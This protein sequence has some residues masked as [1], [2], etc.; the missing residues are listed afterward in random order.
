MRENQNRDFSQ[1]PTAGVFTADHYYQAIENMQEH[2]CFNV[3]WNKLFRRSVIVENSLKMDTSIS[4]GEDLLFV[5]SY[6]QHIR[7]QICLVEKPLYCYFISTNGLQSNFAN[8]QLRLGQLQCIRLLYDKFKYPLAGFYMEAM[9]T[10]YIVLLEN[11]ESSKN[12]HD[13][14]RQPI[15]VEI[16][17]SHFHCGKKYEILRTLLK[18]QN[19]SLILVAVKIFRLIKKTSNRA[20]DWS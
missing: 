11:Q 12:I 7:G 17:K 19:A 2:K 3:L 18:I 5:L 8:W 14:L 16:S 15:S 13:I 10:I 1:M 6:M 9:R 20:F 4:M